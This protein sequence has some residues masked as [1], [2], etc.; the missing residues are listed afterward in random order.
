MNDFSELQ[1]IILTILKDGKLYSGK[2]LLKVSR[3]NSILRLK[4][5]LLHLL[6]LEQVQCHGSYWKIASNAVP[7]ELDADLKTTDLC[8]RCPR[9]QELLDTPESPDGLKAGCP[10]CGQRFIIGPEKLSPS[11]YRAIPMESR[12]L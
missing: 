2:E 5:E 8:V 6:K 12:K 3:E 7:P 9:C 1:K 11:Q 10:F 4:E